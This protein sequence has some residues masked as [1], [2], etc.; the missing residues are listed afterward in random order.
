MTT[1]HNICIRAKELLAIKE[2]RCSYVQ[3][4]LFAVGL[5]PKSAIILTNNH[6]NV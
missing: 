6:N 1:F 3:L 5:Q 2:I 4:K